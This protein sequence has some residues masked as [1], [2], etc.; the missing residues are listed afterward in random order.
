MFGKLILARLKIAVRSKRYIFWNLFFP[1][2]LGTLFFFA[3][4]TIYDSFKS[5]PIPVA[6]EVSDSAIEEYRVLQ[7]FSMFDSDKLQKD[8][9]QYYTDKATAEAM[10]KD[11]DKEPPISEEDLKTLDNIESFED[12][13]STPLSI[14]KDEYLT[15]NIDSI[16]NKDLPL[17]QVL[18]EL[19][20]EDG[21][22]M[23]EQISFKDHA[24][25][26]QLLSDGDIAG[27]ITIDGLRDVNL[28]INGEGVNHS[29]LSSII[30]E[31]LLQVDLT[32]DKISANSDEVDDMNTAIDSSSFNLE[33]IESKT[34]SGENKDPFIPYFYNLIAMVCL[35]GATASLNSLVNTQANQNATGIRIDSSPINKIVL[36]LA[37]LIAVTFI[38]SIIIC[39]MLTYLIFGLGL[40]FGGNT[41]YIYLTSLLATLTGTLIGY[42]IGHIGRLKLEAKEAISMVIFLGGGFMSGLM[43]GD[44]KA[45]MEERFPLFNRINPS[46]VVTDAFLS[47]NL[48]GVGRNYYRS[49]ISLIVFDLVLLTLGILLSRRKSYKSL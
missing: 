46:S 21:V 43:Y 45:I 35:M 2:G 13:T 9:E 38:Q 5:K 6:V 33:Y 1:L 16:T 8:M 29:I 44:M 40:Q 48:Y 26:E 41:A 19:E 20:Y 25:A 42:F 24:E 49:I 17:I 11:F 10:G 18:D 7:A 31:Y 28:L 30:S 39:I 36:E 4:G 14:F 32:I 23:V 12:I 22:K 27:I 34:Y 15:G 3:F 47:L 37:D